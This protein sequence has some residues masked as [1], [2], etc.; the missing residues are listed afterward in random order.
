MYL[1]VFVDWV[2]VI[3]IGYR[4]VAVIGNVNVVTCFINLLEIEKFLVNKEFV[5]FEY[6][7]FAEI[8][9]REYLSYKAFPFIDLEINVFVSFPL[10]T[11]NAT[12]SN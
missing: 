4:N 6:S 12:H 3:K 1:I 9:F 10:T 8:C 7:I 2:F 5:Q 11:K